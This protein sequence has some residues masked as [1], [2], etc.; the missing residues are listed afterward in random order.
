VTEFWQAR[1]AEFWQRADDTSPD[2]MLAVMR[3]LVGERPDGDPEALYEWASVHD[4]LGREV[5]AVPLY[6]AALDA[7][8]D[9]ARRSRAVVQ[10]ASSLRNVGEAAAAVELLDGFKTDDDAEPA[11][12]AFLALA[13]HDLGRH[14]DALAVALKAL[15]PTLPLYRRA[16]EHYAGSLTGSRPGGGGRR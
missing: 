5:E 13:L 14:D 3:E 2:R 11:S 4:F 7:G 10:L 16:V 15:A 12:K 9:G 1:V 8:L 6:R